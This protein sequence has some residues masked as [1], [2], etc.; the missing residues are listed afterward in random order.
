MS[1]LSS[2]VRNQKAPEQSK[3]CSGVNA[4]SIRIFVARKIRPSGRRRVCAVQ[5]FSPQAKP[6]AQGGFPAQPLAALPPYGCG[7]P[8]AGA[9]ARACKSKGWRPPPAAGIQKER[10][11][12]LVMSFFLVRPKGLEQCRIRFTQIYMT[13]NRFSLSYNL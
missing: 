8:L 7:V 9:S 4:R 12:L 5:V 13:L 6:L 10:H 2:A 1:T 11:D 3:L